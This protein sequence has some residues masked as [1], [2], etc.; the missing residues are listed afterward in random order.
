MYSLIGAEEQGGGGILR[1][2][3]RSRKEEEGILRTVLRSR[4]RRRMGHREQC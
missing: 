3:S 4:G 2:V 1:T